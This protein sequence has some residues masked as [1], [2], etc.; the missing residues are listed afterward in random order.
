MRLESQNG[1]I[2]KIIT[3]YPKCKRINNFIAEYEISF[4]ISSKDIIGYY[5]VG[6]IC[7]LINAQLEE[8]A[9]IQKKLN[10]NIYNISFRMLSN[11][12]LD[13]FEQEKICDLIDEMVKNLK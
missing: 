12:I 7:N 10:D 3:Y 2:I 5:E 8:S 6:E 1:K 9:C 11:K 13:I 4:N